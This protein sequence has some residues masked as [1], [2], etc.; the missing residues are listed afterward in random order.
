MPLLLSPTPYRVQDAS[1]AELPTP[2]DMD[3][4][5]AGALLGLQSPSSTPLTPASHPMSSPAPHTDAVSEGVTSDLA[6]QML[7]MAAAAGTAATATAAAAG[8]TPSEL[9]MA[10]QL[11]AEHY[12]EQQAVLDAAAC[13]PVPSPAAPAPAAAAAAANQLEPNPQLQLQQEEEEEDAAYVL[14]SISQ[15]GNNKLSAGAMKA[16]QHLPVAH[17]VGQLA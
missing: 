17:F 11:L 2:M 10:C 6:A 8:I 12:Y 13:M 1:T 5:E 14:V 15:V 9:A 4:E 16:A 3:M 7:Q